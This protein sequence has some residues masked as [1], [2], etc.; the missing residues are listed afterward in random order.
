MD[1][2]MGLYP[3]YHLHLRSLPHSATDLGIQWG[4]YVTDEGRVHIIGQHWV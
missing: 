3:V 1:F 4:N 2:L